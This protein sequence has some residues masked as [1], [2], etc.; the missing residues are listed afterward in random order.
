MLAVIIGREEST[1][2]NHVCFDK[3]GKILEGD[4]WGI[5]QGYT[6]RLI[7]SKKVDGL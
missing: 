4:P 2:N 6:Y 5:Y 7:C 1:L 3:F